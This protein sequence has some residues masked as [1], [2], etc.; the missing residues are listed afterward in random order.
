MATATGIW[1]YIKECAQLLQWMYFKPYTL[2]KY[3]SEL[4][5]DLNIN[6]DV[7]RYRNEFETNPRLK[8]YADQ[9]L[10][11][12]AIVPILITAIVAL[13]YV[14]V[15]HT[16]FRF[17][18]SGFFLLG[19]IVGIWLIKRDA[20]KC[21]DQVTT[22]VNFAILI[23]IVGA[24][25]LLISIG[26]DLKPD[27]M[28][29]LGSSLKFL[30]PFLPATKTMLAIRSFTVGVTGGVV[31]GLAFSIVGGVAVSVA[32]AIAGGVAFGDAGGA[33][34][35]IIFGAV[36]GVVFGVAVS[37][38]S[39]IA[40]VI[41]GCVTSGVIFGV[42][43]S[44]L[45]GFARGLADGFT[46]VST[47]LFAFI[48][49]VLR[50]YFWLPEFLWTIFLNFTVAPQFTAASLRKLPPY[51]DQLIYLPLP[52]IDNLIIEAHRENPIAARSTIDY[53]ITSTN[54]QKAAARAQQG[55]ALET[56]G[57]CQTPGDIAAIAS[58]LDWIPANDNPIFGP[59]FP[60]FLSISQ[61]VQAAYDSTTAYRK[62]ELIESPIRQLETSVKASPYKTPPNSPPSTARSPIDGK[63]SLP[64][65]ASPSP[66]PPKQNPKSPIPTSPETH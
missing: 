37:T 52:F 12:T 23:C 22:L 5:S 9:T 27:L 15:T 48:L 43:V 65:A 3:L 29:V 31:V 4:H 49:G 28:V 21:P 41:S 46:G 8:R 18:T 58:Q 40:V 2:R 34:V 38:L 53:L 44:V 62:L 45:I 32:F 56:L 13:I 36:F 24:I 54:Q 61:S 35:S 39:G 57:L 19:W 10:W 59:T 60:K 66:P 33:T 63:P 30:S 47:G 14:G 7:F 64:K 16:E 51:L 25:V 55:I 11:L 6:S 17:S 1:E 42:L 50:I 26:N 20:G